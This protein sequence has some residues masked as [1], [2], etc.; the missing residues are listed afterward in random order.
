[1]LTT[2]LERSPPVPIRTNI[3]SPS[4][5]LEY[6]AISELRTELHETLA[7]LPSRVDE[8]YVIEDLLAE[9]KGINSQVTTLRDLM[10]G[11]SSRLWQNSMIV[12]I[13]T[14]SP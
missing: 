13:Q 14:S 6:A 8:A 4:H 3:E 2:D 11:S 10:R 5:P 1:V 7:S 12:D 9:H